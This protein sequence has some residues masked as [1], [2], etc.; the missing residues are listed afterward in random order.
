MPTLAALAVRLLA[1]AL[2][3]AACLAGQATLTR[4]DTLR[5]HPSGFSGRI[6]EVQRRSTVEVLEVRQDWLRVMAPGN[7]SG[8]ILRQNTDL[9][10]QLATPDMPP[11]VRTAPATGNSGLQSRGSPR[12]SNH[13]LI[14]G[15]DPVNTSA[16]TRLA[17]LMGVPDGNIRYI[18][19]PDMSLDALRRAFVDADARLGDGDR[20]L[21]HVTQA[22]PPDAT[23]AVA[24]RAC[25]DGIPTTDRQLFR[26]DEL[27][28]HVGT[29]A[30]RS[31]KI[32]LV[33]DS[34]SPGRGN[35]PS[36]YPGGSARPALPAN[37]LALAD[38]GQRITPAL[39]ACLEGDAPGLVK[40]FAD[41]EAL[42]RCVQG[43][44]GSAGPA[45]R[46]AGNAALVPV[47]RA[48]QSPAGNQDSAA[49]LLDV[50]YAQ[51]DQRSTPDIRQQ[52]STDGVL[53]F[54]AA[55]Q[56]PAYL[57]ALA[58]TP[59]GIAL[60]HPNRHD[61]E[62]RLD[63]GHAVELTLPALPGGT[64][65]LLFVLTD[66]PRSMQRAGF[67]ASGE[68]ASS[69]P[70]TTSLYRALEEFLGGDNS[71]TCRL[72]ETRNLGAAQARQCAT[73]FS[74]KWITPASGKATR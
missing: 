54:R 67:I 25:P 38:G 40:A 29:L 35:C 7:R 60:L 4:P 47:P 23:P 17:S 28:Q 31:E 69:G 16:A 10:A 44:P 32:F 50:L 5:E 61:S 19:R 53:R 21:I 59:D 9:D 13:A 49:R 46:L 71:P 18:P 11:A 26:T 68:S 41:G 14:I 6:M 58:A 3:A 36:P 22:A 33:T 43:A 55:T 8:W 39:L 72:S 66:G 57:Y 51:R 24:R 63:A 15:G 30:R 70:D 42:Q 12:A 2:P 65:R 48:L 1:L 74:A 62:A 34:A 64:Q 27:L 52:A 56:D 45:L 37:V 73:R 20:L